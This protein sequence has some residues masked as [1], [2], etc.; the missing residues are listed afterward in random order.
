MFKKLF[1]AASLA[2]FMTGCSSIKMADSAQDE[3]RKEFIAPDDKAGVYIYRNELFGGAV[4]MDVKVNDKQLGST[5]SHTYLYTELPEGKHTISSIAENTSEVELDVKKGSL[6]Y[7]WQ[8]VK[9]GIISARSKLQL[10]DEE[11]GKNGVLESK[12]AQSEAL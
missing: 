1:I 11:E 3:Q 9:M 6:Y 7:L 2:V 10:V 5:G 8:E 4:S 12:L